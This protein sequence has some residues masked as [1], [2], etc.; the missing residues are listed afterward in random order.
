[1]DEAMRSV[2]EQPYPDVEYVVIDGGSTDG[3]VDVIKKYADRLAYWVSEKDAGHFDAL[4]KGFA[5]TSGEV[6]AFINSDDKYCPWAF[7]IVGEIFAKFPQID[8]LTTMFPLLW[9]ADGRATHCRYTE[10]F[11]REGF[12]R[13]EN[14]RANN[15]SFSTHWIQQ[16]STFWRRSLWE[17]AGGRVDRTTIAGDFELWA[18]FYQHAELYAVNTPLGGFRWHGDQVT[19]HHMDKYMKVCGE[20]LARHGG[21]PHGKLPTALMRSRVGRYLPARVKRALKL[22]HRRP[23]VIHGGSK[24]GWQIKVV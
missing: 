24:I 7:Q 14:L 2:L 21:R 3:T 4:H 9:D 1:M 22:Q 23:I 17:K 10:G 12:L 13:G 15:G 6:M 5:R 20:I 11:S 8:W 19:G 18:R 16:E